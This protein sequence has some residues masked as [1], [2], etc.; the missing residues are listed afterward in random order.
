MS[1]EARF[2]TSWRWEKQLKSVY[3]K[4]IAE[5]LKKTT[6]VVSYCCC[7]SKHENDYQDKVTKHINYTEDSDGKL[8]TTSEN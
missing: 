6:K 4:D 2:H 1:T 7:Y 5:A 3:V 8:A